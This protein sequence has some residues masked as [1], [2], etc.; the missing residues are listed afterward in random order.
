MAETVIKTE[1]LTKRY[2]GGCLA[3]SGLDLSV[4]EGEFAC[5]LGPNGAGKTT[6]ISLLF[7]FIRPTAGRAWVCG[8]DV[9]EESMEARRA[10]AFVPERVA[11][12]ENLT[13]VQNVTFFAE[14]GGLRGNLRDRC[15]KA[16]LDAGL[17][18]EDLG[19]R[20]GQFSKGMRQ[21]VAL[22]AALVRDCKVVVL[23]EPTSGLDPA[24]AENLMQR[25]AALVAQGTTVL[26]STHDIFRVDELADRVFL[27]SKGKLVGEVGK[28]ELGKGKLVEIYMDVVAR[29]ASVEPAGVVSG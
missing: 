1:G 12:F 15:R 14:L 22:A 24:A 2:E 9:V 8:H 25:L 20:V 29:S 21:K 10:M 4:G 11:L 7:G 5:L 19:R 6:M 17:A 16:L 13:A 3:L 27:L 18:P 28:Q 23:D 26:M